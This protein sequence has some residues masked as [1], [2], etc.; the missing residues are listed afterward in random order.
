MKHKPAPLRRLLVPLML[1]ALLQACATPSPDS[2]L[3]QCQ[4]TQSL[5]ATLAKR[6]KPES[7][8]E[9]AQQNIEA[10]QQKLISSEIK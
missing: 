10:W 2:T 4:S 8:S 5:P 1:S 7:Y 9:R 3:A 6:P